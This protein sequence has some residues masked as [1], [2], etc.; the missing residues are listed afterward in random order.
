MRK[1]AIAF[2]ALMAV[3]APELSAQISLSPYSRYGLGD[4]FNPSSTRNYAMGGIGIGLYDGATVNRINPASYADIRLTTI[5]INGFSLFSQQK[6]NINERN[7]GT[8]GF[9]NVSLAFANRKGFGFVAGL[10]PYS[11]AGYDVVVNDQLLVDSVWKPYALTYSADGGLSQFYI[12]AGF[13]FLRNFYAGTNLTYAFGTTNFGFR[14]DFEDN[15]Y[16]PVTTSERVSLRGFLPQLGVQYGDTLVI[17]SKI[18]RKKFLEQQDAILQK[19]LRDLDKEETTLNKEVEKTAAWEIAQ[20]KKITEIETEK[21]GTS[22]RIE[23]LMTNEE[24]N[25][26]EIGQLQDRNFRLEKKR[27]KIQREIKAR[28]R[29]NK[30]TRAR[31]DGRRKKISQRRQGLATEIEKIVNGGKEATAE[32]RRTFLLRIGGI[33]EPSA[34]LNGSRLVEFDNLAIK[35]TLSNTDGTVRLPMKYGGGIT[36]ARPNR[37]LVGIDAT[38]QDW[39]NFEF[40][41]EANTL[42]GAFKLNVGGEWIPDLL[43]RSYFKRVAYRFG[44][45]YQSTFLNLDGTPIDEVGVNFGFGFPIGLFNPISATYSRINFG[46]GI[47][48]RGTLDNN[49]MEELT[50]QFRLGVN[51]N[52][53]WFIRR[54]I[55]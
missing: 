5:D 25:S 46:F 12:G 37:W 38:Y 40:F 20:Q 6:S 4:L 24:Q 28:T 2:L 19:Q 52:D 35:D 33:L 1:Y 18:D 50:Y 8:A 39:S 45:H 53:I 15:T 47:S 48:K 17:K 21:S 41:D 31:L 32:R 13:R 55:D 42:N 16:L 54:R 30:E 27:K 14:S 34:T 49:L 36:I 9:H 23:Q 51:L 43:S 11:S 3:L 22:Y 44:G 26:K 10:A 7:L 29:T